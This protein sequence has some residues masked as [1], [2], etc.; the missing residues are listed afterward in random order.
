MLR[1]SF[2][3]HLKIVKYN[4]QKLTKNKLLAITHL[5]YCIGIGRIK[6]LGLVDNNLN[7]EK[8]LKLP[9]KNNREFE[10]KLFYK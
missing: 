3:N 2:N 7:I 5:S 9:H 8:L 10:V 1:K 4:Y 6:K